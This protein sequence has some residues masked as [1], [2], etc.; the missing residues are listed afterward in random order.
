M[1]RG[2][3][4]N[5]KSHI[6]IPINGRAQSLKNIADSNSKIKMNHLKSSLFP[7]TIHLQHGTISKP[8][9]NGDLF[10]KTLSVKTTGKTFARY[11]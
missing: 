7:G 8:T 1:I 11:Y 2:H 5:K 6:I 3:L 9:I 4:P 10:S